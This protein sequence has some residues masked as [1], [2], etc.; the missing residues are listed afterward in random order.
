[1]K[2]NCFTYEQIIKKQF[3]EPI[4]SIELNENEDFFAILKLG[5][6]IQTTKN[7]HVLFIHVVPF[8]NKTYACFPSSLVESTYIKSDNP[9]IDT[10]LC[11]RWTLKNQKLEYISG[12]RDYKNFEKQDNILKECYKNL[13]KF[14]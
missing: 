5:P 14:T 3:T 7:S 10:G 8:E 4:N 13:K 2:I 12:L 1:M 6:F 9:S 11:G